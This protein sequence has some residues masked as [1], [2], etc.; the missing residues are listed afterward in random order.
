MDFIINRDYLMILFIKFVKFGSTIYCQNQFYWSYPH[1]QSS[2]YLD[3][4]T[5]KDYWILATL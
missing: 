2:Y 3:W 5:T 4:R 1:F